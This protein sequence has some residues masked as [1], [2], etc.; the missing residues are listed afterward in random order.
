MVITV[1]TYQ[2]SNY[3]YRLN[4]GAHLNQNRVLPCFTSG[5]GLCVLSINRGKMLKT[6]DEF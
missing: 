6:K 2:V 1:V 3:T 5:L 4:G